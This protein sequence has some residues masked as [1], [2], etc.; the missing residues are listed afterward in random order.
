MI[1][2]CDREQYRTV[3]SI[4]YGK[5]KLWIFARKEKYCTFLRNILLTKRTQRSKCFNFDFPFAKIHFFK[6]ISLVKLFSWRT[7]CFIFFF[8]SVK[9]PKQS[10][11]RTFGKEADTP[12]KYR[13]FERN[14]R[15]SF[16]NTTGHVLQRNTL[17]YW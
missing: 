7:A 15:C 11:M 6:T 10:W 13:K 1:R 17:P 4:F 5:N 12:F 2:I 3:E 9:V 16:W 8:N 14:H